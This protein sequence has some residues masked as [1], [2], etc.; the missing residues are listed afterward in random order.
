MN[1]KL[2]QSKL[3]FDNITTEK[4]GLIDQVLKHQNEEKF[5]EIEKK[6]SL[7]EANEQEFG[8]TMTDLNDKISNNEQEIQSLRSANKDLSLSR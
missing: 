6:L 3:D 7:K 1:S 5:R 2:E 4:E 8:I